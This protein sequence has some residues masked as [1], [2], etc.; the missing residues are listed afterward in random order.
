MLYCMYRSRLLIVLLAVL[1]IVLPA[2]L[3]I[4]LPQEKPYHMVYDD[5]D[6]EALALAKEDWLVASDDEKPL[7]PRVSE[8]QRVRVEIQ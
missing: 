1:L 6:E 4:L 8:K 5:G 3:P 2:L 7:P